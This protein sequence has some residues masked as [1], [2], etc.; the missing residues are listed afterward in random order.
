MTRAFSAAGTMSTMPMPMLKARYCSSSVTFASLEMAMNTG[1]TGHVPFFIITFTF[2]GRMRGMFSMKPPP[3][4]CA[5][6]CTVTPASSTRS[7]A[8]A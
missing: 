1:S 3:V 7:T 4:R 5:M 6:P 2:F 8:G